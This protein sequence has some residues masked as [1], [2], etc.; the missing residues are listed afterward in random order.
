MFPASETVTYRVSHKGSMAM[1]ST[2]WSTTPVASGQG[3]GLAPSPPFHFTRLHV[4]FTALDRASR[5]RAL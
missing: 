4:D 3:K 1:V 2:Y 5:R